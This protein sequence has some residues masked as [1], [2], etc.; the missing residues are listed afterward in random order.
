VRAIP[1]AE[2]LRR[3][4]SESSRLHGVVR[5]WRLAESRVNMLSL[6]VWHSLTPTSANFAL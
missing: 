6:A 3:R 1:F 2:R 4:T 5:I